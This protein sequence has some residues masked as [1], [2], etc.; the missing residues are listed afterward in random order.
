MLA[1]IVARAF[2][3]VP[4]DR[5]WPYFGLLL[6]AF[7]GRGACAWG[8]EIAGR[9]A[10]W[11]VLSELR[12]ALLE[13]RLSAQPTA[14]DGTDGSAVAGLQTCRAQSKVATPRPV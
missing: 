9:R 1:L 6:T 14:V 12:L 7:L 5:L 11:S 10:A 13:K 4:L 2:N 8:M 3:G